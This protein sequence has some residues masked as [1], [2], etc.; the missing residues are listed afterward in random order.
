[1]LWSRNSFATLDW[2]K[3]GKYDWY[4]FIGFCNELCVAAAA[5]AAEATK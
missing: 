5:A 4:C 3:Y 1:M 2:D